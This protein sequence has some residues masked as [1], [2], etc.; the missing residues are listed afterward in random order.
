MELAL[1]DA[2][3]EAS[4][5]LYVNAH[6]TS[7]PLNDRAETNAIKTALG[8]ELAAKIPVSSTK[9][10]IGHLLGAAGAVEAIATL[11]ALRDRIAPP[12]LNYGEPDEG[13]TSTMCRTRHAAAERRR[14]R[15]RTVERVRLRR[16]QRSSLPGGFMSA[17]ADRMPAE[18]ISPLLKEPREVTARD[19][20]ELLCDPGS[21]HVIR[22]TVLPRRESKRM[23]EGDGVVGAAGRSPAA[24]CTATRRTSRSPAARS[25]RRTRT[26]SCASCSSRA[27]RAC[28]SSAS[29]PPAARG[30]TTASPRWAAT[31]A[32]SARA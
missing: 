24:P 9:S 4:D 8:E 26:R 27:A 7:T 2:G 30:W 14:P 17:L 19:R 31:A 10:A 16:P 29:S 11:L 13:S 32:S 5:V 20:L 25:A 3:I 18:R 21:L 6:G 23:R 1:K 12:T 28:R 15:N 22:S